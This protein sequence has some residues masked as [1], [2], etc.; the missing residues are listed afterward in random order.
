MSCFI[1]SDI[2]AT[3]DELYS[4]L[5]QVNQNVTFHTKTYT[6]SIVLYGKAVDNPLK[7]CAKALEVLEKLLCFFPCLLEVLKKVVGKF[8]PSRWRCWKKPSE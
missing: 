3:F 1:L 6:N 4:H 8:F 7:T 2:P 5:A